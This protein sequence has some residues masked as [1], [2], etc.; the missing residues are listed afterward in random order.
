MTLPG[1]GAKPHGRVIAAAPGSS[2][3][4]DTAVPAAD[5]VTAP[6]GDRVEPRAANAMRRPHEPRTRATERRVDR[7]LPGVDLGVDR[8]RGGEGQQAMVVAVAGDLVAVGGELPDEL[9]MLPCRP[10]EHEE[11][12]AVPPLGEEPAD[13]R[14]VPRIRAVVERQRKLPIA[15][16]GRRSSDRPEQRQV[17]QVGAGEVGACEAATAPAV[18]PVARRDAGRS[19]VPRRRARHRRP[20]WRQ[21]CSRLFTSGRHSTS[22]RSRRVC[23]PR[24]A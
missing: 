16:T 17:L 9:G 11:R 24:R 1:A 8:P 18:R 20:R 7:L 5:G 19:G 3:V 21:R 2:G 15:A 14:R 4:E 6:A 22:R 12:R 23:A 13:R 10:A